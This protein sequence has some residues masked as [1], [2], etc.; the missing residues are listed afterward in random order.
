MLGNE[1]GE[2]GVEVAR[3]LMELPEKRKGYA[4]RPEWCVRAGKGE[5][6]EAEVG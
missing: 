3:I 6:Y 2:Q 1:E 4:L 5:G